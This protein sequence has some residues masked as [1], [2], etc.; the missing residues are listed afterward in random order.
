MNSTTALK[1]LTKYSKYRKGDEGVKMH[2]A[3]ISKAI[4][5]AIEILKQKQNEIKSKVSRSIG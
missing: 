5:K 2:P 3:R 1:I 4:D